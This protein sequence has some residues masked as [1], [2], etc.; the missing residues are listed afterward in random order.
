M[1]KIIGFIVVIVGCVLYMSIFSGC[2]SKP[3]TENQMIVQETSE[4]ND[5]LSN[6]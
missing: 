6:R 5:E 4:V 1:D 3:D 2:E